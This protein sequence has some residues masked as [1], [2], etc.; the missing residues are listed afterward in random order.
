MADHGATRGVAEREESGAGWGLP[1]A[2]VVL[3]L[4]LLLAGVRSNP[5]APKGQ[6]V[7]LTE[8]SAERARQVLQTLLGD[9]APHPHGS[10]ANARVRERILTHLR[11]LGLTP[12]VQEGF[13][14]SFGGCG[15]VWN[16]VARLEGTRPGTAEDIMGRRSRAPASTAGSTAATSGCCASP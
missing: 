14:C 3:A 10:E 8:F 5:P 4:V 16:V 15:R 11:W 1:A 9:G 13:A 6:D 7:P 12:E 2:L